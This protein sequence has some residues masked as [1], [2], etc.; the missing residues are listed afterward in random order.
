VPIGRD[1]D[2]DPDAR[3]VASASGAELVAHC[4]FGQFLHEA[5]GLVI[6]DDEVGHLQPAPAGLALGEWKIAR[7]THDL[8]HAGMPEQMRVDGCRL[9]RAPCLEARNARTRTSA[10]SEACLTMSQA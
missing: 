8:A 6:P 9:T 5:A 3:G 10:R 1:L 2:L 7:R 4:S